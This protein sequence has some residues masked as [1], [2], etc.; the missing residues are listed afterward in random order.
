MTEEQV[1]NSRTVLFGNSLIPPGVGLLAEVEKLFGKTVIE[2]E[3]ELVDLHGQT[4]VNEDGSP[5]IV[6]NPKSSRSQESI[7]HEL[8]HL[9]LI[10]E[11]SPTLSYNVLQAIPENLQKAIF[12]L[13]L[14]LRGA[15]QHRMF[16]DHMRSMGLQP[17][18]QLKSDIEQI[19]AGSLMNE[20]NRKKQ[21]ELTV[22][23]TRLLLELKDAELMRRYNAWCTGKMDNK[24]I[25][26]AR[27]LNEIVISS[28]PQTVR[29]E[30][31]T[32]RRCLD[33]LYHDT[34][35]SFVLVKWGHKIL[36]QFQLATA[37]IR[38]LS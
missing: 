1:S 20:V 6:L 36:G 15:I 12:W 29:D 3:N 4:R 8:F 32:Y 7:I 31:E 33:R 35:T 22:L 23:Y 24:S 26:K 25:T 18:V 38:V 27:E 2:E 14:Q 34:G 5:V 17:D 37:T 19:L 11:G 13:E 30:I 9:K 28:N 16:Y 21:F 10:G